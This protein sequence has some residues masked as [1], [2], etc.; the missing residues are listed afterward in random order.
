MCHIFAGRTACIAM[1]EI[2][3]THKLAP[4]LDIFK[5]QAA[6]PCR[7]LSYAD[8]MPAAVYLQ[9]AYR[10]YASRLIACLC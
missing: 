5:R 3:A 6:V 4:E 10:K 7:L 2:L 9:A 8:P 1:I